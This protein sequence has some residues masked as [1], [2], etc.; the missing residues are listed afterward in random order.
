[1]ADLNDISLS[2]QDIL[3]KQFKT[4]VK[5]ID[6]DEVDAFLDQIIA[7]YDTFEQIIEDL[8]GQIGKLQGELMTDQR[9]TQD[10]QQ[11]NQ[12]QSSRQRLNQSEDVR[13]YI[14]TSR[15]SS[16]NFASANS[17]QEPQTE[18]STNMAIIQRISTL[19]R[20]VYNLEQLVSGLQKQ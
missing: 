18:R 7:D 2:T 20:K 13:T 14:P 12:D 19:E 5:G 8:Y 6:P 17:K 10:L 11:K 4:K 16:L 9:K 1:M 3:K 15:N